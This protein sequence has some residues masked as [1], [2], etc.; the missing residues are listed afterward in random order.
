MVDQGELRGSLPPPP[1]IIMP[2][3]QLKGYLH[4][5]DL[6]YTRPK[7]VKVN[8]KRPDCR[9]VSVHS[10]FKCR[11]T[12]CFIPHLNEIS[13][14]WTWETNIKHPPK[15]T[16]LNPLRKGSNDLPPA[17]LS[18]SAWP[19]RSFRL[20]STGRGGAPVLSLCQSRA[21]DLLQAKS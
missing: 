15:N 17:L 3:M 11:K 7:L 20:L 9:N 5:A 1:L 14:R 6:I 19:L 10:G 8:F 13:S 21:K 16:G 12:I 2:H 18:V 4:W